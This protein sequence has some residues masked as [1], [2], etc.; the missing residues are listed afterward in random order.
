ME[1]VG[2]GKVPEICVN[3]RLYH[4][5]PHRTRS[6]KGIVHTAAQSFSNRREGRQVFAFLLLRILRREI[7]Y[8]FLET[9]VARSG[10]HLGCSFNLP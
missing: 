8:I 10:S 9:W 4:Y 1:H 3:H 7:G 2:S 5:K 6:D